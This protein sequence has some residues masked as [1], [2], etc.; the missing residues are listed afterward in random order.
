MV[1]EE[2][3]ITAAHAEGNMIEGKNLQISRAY[4]NTKTMNMT[5]EL[6]TAIPPGIIAQENP[7]PQPQLMRCLMK[8]NAMPVSKKLVL[9]LTRAKH[10]GIR[11]PLTVLK[12]AKAAYT[13]MS[14]HPEASKARS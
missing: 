9:N 13:T 3:G 14:V 8:N 1:A 4:M 6:K 12:Q 2:Q 5:A 11:I 7:V 10:S